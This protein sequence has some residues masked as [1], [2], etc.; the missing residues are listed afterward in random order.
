[1]STNIFLQDKDEEMLNAL[2]E[3]LPDCRTKASLVRKTVKLL[4]IALTEGNTIYIKRPDGEPE[5]LVLI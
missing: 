4:E 2:M 5:R 1:M 3:R